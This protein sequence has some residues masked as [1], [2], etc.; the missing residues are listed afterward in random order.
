MLMI[1]VPPL[2][3]STKVNVLVCV[4]GLMSRTAL[5]SLDVRSGGAHRDTSGRRLATLLGRFHLACHMVTIYR[6]K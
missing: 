6:D 1:A 2:K 5:S 4:R 3:T